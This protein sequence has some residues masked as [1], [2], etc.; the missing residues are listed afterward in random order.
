M[1]LLNNDEL[2]SV[3]GGFGAGLIPGLIA[4]SLTTG[5][6]LLPFYMMGAGMH[7]PTKAENMAFAGLITAGGLVGGAIGFLTE[8]V[9]G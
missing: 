6:I 3:S 4:G 2:E 7:P 5:L 1:I 9:L 8:L